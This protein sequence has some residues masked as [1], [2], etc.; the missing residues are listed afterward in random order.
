MVRAAR[1]W[2]VA[3]CALLAGACGTPT[4]PAPAA[5]SATS[6]SVRG[7][8]S[9]VETLVFVVNDDQGELGRRLQPY[10][11]RPTRAPEAAVALWR[12]NGL[13]VV[14]VPVDEVDSLRRA[15]RLLGGVQRE[16]RGLVPLW[17]EIVRGPEHPDGLVIAM[18]DG[19]LRLG[20]GRLRLLGRCWA[21]P[22]IVSGNGITRVAPDLRLELVPQYNDPPPPRPS[23]EEE[24]EKATKPPRPRTE[25]REGLLIRRLVLDVPLLAGEAVVIVPERPEANWS[26][27]AAERPEAGAERGPAPAAP[28]FP[29]VGEAMLSDA[30]AGGLGLAKVVVVVLPRIPSGFRLADSAAGG[31]AS[32]GDSR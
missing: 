19:R 1:R 26:M 23:L 13:R 21:A 30:G 15:L 31:R 3:G 29:T 9:G 20:P 11:D 28:L 32:A 7:A 8:E 18:H 5:D 10:A 17:T 22:T 25:E 2:I 24:L 16:W 27:P 12:A 14:A 4:A 6:P